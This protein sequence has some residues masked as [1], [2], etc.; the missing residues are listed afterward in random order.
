MIKSSFAEWTKGKIEKTFGIK[1][2][3]HHPLLLDWEETARSVPLS[4]FELL[5][6]QYFEGK[7]YQ[8]CR[9]M[10]RTGT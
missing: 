2:V 1:R 4:D 3:L 5:S 7:A 8:S 10:E 9:C 6:L